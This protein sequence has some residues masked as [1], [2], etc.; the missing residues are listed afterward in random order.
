MTVVRA[1]ASGWN[2]SHRRRV[3]ERIWQNNNWDSHESRSGP[4]S[5]L[6]RTQ[7]F[8]LALEDFLEKVEARTLLD[9][10]CG[11]FNWMRHVQLPAGCAYVGVDIVEPMIS[12]LQTQFAS[13]AVKFQHGDI[14]C[15]PPPPADV[16]LCR[17]SLFHFTLRDAGRVL[18]AWRASRIPWFLATTSPD[19]ERNSDIR[20]GSFRPMNL[21]R[22]PFNLGTPVLRLPDGTRGDPGKVVGVWVHPDMS[23]RHPWSGTASSKPTRSGGRQG[24]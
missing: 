22:R 2:S 7:P 24:L 21:E 18:S 15:A 8:R 12:R 4:G 16:W 1:L 11:D 10:P 9:A 13:E 17:E 23:V 5:E 3:F 19:V 20:S 14:V 6:A